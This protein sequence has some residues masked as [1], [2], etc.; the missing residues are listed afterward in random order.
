MHHIHIKVSQVAMF[1]GLL[2]P[3]KTSSRWHKFPLKNICLLCYLK[4]HRL[5]LR[6]P[7]L[8]S[9]S[10]L[11]PPPHPSP[12]NLSTSYSREFAIEEALHVN[13]I[14]TSC[15][16]LV[17]SISWRVNN[18]AFARRSAIN[19]AD[20]NFLALEDIDVWIRW[21]A[22]KWDLLAA[23]TECRRLVPH[24]GFHRYEQKLPLSM[25]EAVHL[26]THQR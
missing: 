12:S 23:A 13:W 16:E 3:S 10:V 5:L 15:I 25:E 1:R 19:L 21:E 20:R 6:Y 9:P 26:S 17:V 7:T 18:N 11:F 24:D 22:S 2:Y 14:K 4:F 8:F